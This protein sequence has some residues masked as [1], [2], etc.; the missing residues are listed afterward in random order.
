MTH[1]VSSDAAI[2]AAVQTEL[3]WDA[4]VAQTEVGVEVERGV[5]TISGTV[6]SWAKSIAAE[7]AAHRAPGVLDVVNEL[8]IRIPDGP[9]QTDSELAHAVRQALSWSACL[10][11]RQ[12]ASTVSAGVVALEGTVTS[13]TERD[14]AE[15]IVREV[16]G[17]QRVVN[18]LRVVPPASDAG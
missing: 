3:R 18:K 5:V 16:K 1:G 12:I 14:D 8:R 6:S 10:P 7:Q 9:G 13:W 2:Q 15:R 11:H 17:V 4:R